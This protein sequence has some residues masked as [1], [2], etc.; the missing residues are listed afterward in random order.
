MLTGGL[1]HSGDNL[2]IDLRLISAASGDR[3]WTHRFDEP[4]RRRSSIS[5]AVS[6]SLVSR[7]KLSVTP[8]EEH[9]LHAPP[10][11]DPEAYDDF[12]R[13]K[14]HLLRANPRDY[15]I[16][17]DALEQAVARDS[18]LAVAHAYLAYAYALC[19]TFFYTPRD[20]A[21]LEKS[22]VTVEKVATTRSRSGGG[23][24]CARLLP[25][26][27]VS[28]FAHQQAIQEFRRAI[29][30]NPNLAEAHQWLGVVY[31]HTGLFEKAIEQF[32][33]PRRSTPTTAPSGSTSVC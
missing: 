33:S 31:W 21:M 25:R 17:T 14:I 16:A 9:Q 26:T 15:S 12:L 6:R 23:P 5:D 13:G 3:L 24:L 20:T 1:Q 19:G 22:L 28:H 4:F 18:G 8:T 2:R 30:L 27:R 7:L 29:A 32:R 10:T 11:T